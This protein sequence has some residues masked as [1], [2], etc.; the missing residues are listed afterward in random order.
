M[1]FSIFDELVFT[2]ITMQFSKNNPARFARR[3]KFPILDRR[4]SNRNA[5]VQEPKMPQAARPKP[6]FRKAKKSGRA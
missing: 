5:I 1:I 6:L 4:R 3:I 2:Q